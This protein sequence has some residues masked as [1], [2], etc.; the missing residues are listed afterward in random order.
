MIEI[1]HNFSHHA[2]AVGIETSADAHE[3][4]RLGCDIGQGHFFGK[5]MT[6]QGLMTLLMRGRSESKNFY[7]SAVWHAPAGHDG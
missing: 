7:K 5:P 2:T 3:I 1:A 6:E 4:T